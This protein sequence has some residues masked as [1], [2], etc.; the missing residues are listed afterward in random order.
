MPKTSAHADLAWQF[1]AFLS[2]DQASSYANTVKLASSAK[3]KDFKPS[4]RDRTGEN[5][6]GRSQ[7]QT[8]KMWI[9]GRYPSGDDDALRTAIDN[10]VSGKQDSQSAI[11]LAANT[12]TNLLRKETW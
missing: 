3:Q 8:A 1:V 9:K 2:I 11:D 6:P 5:N 10:V 7:S 12:I 4:L